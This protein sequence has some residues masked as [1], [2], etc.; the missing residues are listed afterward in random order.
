MNAIHEKKDVTYFSKTDSCGILRIHNIKLFKTYCEYQS[1]GEQDRQNR[2]MALLA[3]CCIS[4]MNK[5]PQSLKLRETQSPTASNRQSTTLFS[6]YMTTRQWLSDSD[7][8]RERNC[9]SY[10]DTQTAISANQLSQL[11]ITCSNAQYSTSNLEY[12]QCMQTYVHVLQ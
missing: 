10:S 6:H 5:Q 2:Q 1:Y 11:R 12:A 3:T 7:L 4:Y 9:H 8:S